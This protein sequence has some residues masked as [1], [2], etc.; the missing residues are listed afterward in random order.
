[1]RNCTQTKIKEK[2]GKIKRSLTKGLQ[3]TPPDWNI[4]SRYKLTLPSPRPLSALS[5]ARRH[6]QNF[7]A[8]TTGW[9]EECKEKKSEMSLEV[10]KKIQ[11]IWLGH[12]GINFSSERGFTSFSVISFMLRCNI[13]LYLHHLFTKFLAPFKS[14]RKLQAFTQHL[15]LSS[16]LGL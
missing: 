1:M 2:K 8:P 6:C 15:S 14:T 12:S 11:R 10:S 4:C 9:K 7:L 13:L 5:H 3:Q 16:R